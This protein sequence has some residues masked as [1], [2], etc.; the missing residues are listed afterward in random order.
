MH[1]SRRAMTGLL[2]VDHGSRRTA[3][4]ALLECVVAVVAEMAGPDVMVVAAHM[5]LC[6]PDIDEAMRRLV[7]AGI[8]SIKVVP[9]FLGPGRHATE[10]IPRLAAEAAA[11][12]P[13][14]EVTVGA[15]LGVHSDLARV[16]LDRAGLSVCTEVDGDCTGDP[17][18]CRAPY[19]RR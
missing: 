5:E 6:P 18:T 19:C 13:D 16:V 1:P 11:A 2:L 17:A 15:P 4:N 3:A 7:D 8:T 12:H 9:Y 10:D 14:V